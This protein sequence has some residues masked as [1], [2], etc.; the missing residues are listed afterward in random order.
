MQIR[1]LECGADSTEAP[2]AQVCARCGGP[3]RPAAVRGSGPSG[4]RG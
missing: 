1:C 4:R 3:Y 2:Q